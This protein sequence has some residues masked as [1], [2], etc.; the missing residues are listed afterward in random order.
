MP[1]RANKPTVKRQSFCKPNLMPHT[2]GA[3]EFISFDQILDPCEV[4]RSEFAQIKDAL[5]SHV[6]NALVQK[7]Q[8]RFLVLNST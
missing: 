7:I 1:G 3:N 6:Y 4:A 5:F 8:D 2:H